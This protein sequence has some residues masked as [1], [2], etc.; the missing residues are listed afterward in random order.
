M[1]KS[2]IKILLVIIIM[3]IGFSCKK[4][5]EAQWKEPTAVVFNMDINRSSCLGGNLLFNGGNILLDNFSFEGKRDQGGDVYFDKNSGTLYAS[6]DPNAT[7]PEWNF[8]IPQGSYSQIKISYKTAGSPSD[9]QIVVLGS[10]TNTVNNN[11]YPVRFEFQAPQ[12]FVIFA[13]TS[14]GNSQIVLDKNVGSTATIR[15]DPVYW[16]QVITTTMMDNASITNL[17]GVPTILINKNT[18]NNINAA[19]QSR[20]HDDVTQVIFN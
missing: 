19:M 2:Y 17:N 6:F 7:I 3:C 1:Y 4:K 12:T 14:S 20:V 16:F 9:K 10:Y 18:N 11:V 8:D 5:K 13:K 15:M